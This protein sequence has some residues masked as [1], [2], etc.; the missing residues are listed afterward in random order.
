MASASLAAAVLGAVLEVAAVAFEPLNPQ[1]SECSTHLEPLEC[2]VVS[3]GEAA[4]SPSQV[5]APIFSRAAQANSVFFTF[6]YPDL[7][8]ADWPK[9]DYRD[10]WGFPSGGMQ[11]A[12][13][14]HLI[15]RLE[16]KQ[17][18]TRIVRSASRLLQQLADAAVR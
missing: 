11:H 2:S 10:E 16:A 6:V 17:S 3:A 15:R 14:K 1:S 18:S 9:L 8:T 4:S 7:L 5:N 13:S 12:R